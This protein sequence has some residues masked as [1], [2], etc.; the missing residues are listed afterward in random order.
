MNLLLVY[1]HQAEIIIVK[2]I[3]QGRN[4]V[5]RVESGTY[6]YDRIKNDSILLS[7]TL[8]TNHL[9]SDKPP[10]WVGQKFQF[11]HLIV[12][13]FN[14]SNR[15]IKFDLVKLYLPSDFQNSCQTLCSILF[16][17]KR[18]LE[19]QRITFFSYFNPERTVENIWQIKMAKYVSSNIVSNETPR[20]EGDSRA[21]KNFNLPII[22]FQELEIF[23]V[24]HQ[25]FYAG[26][27]QADSNL[28][29]LSHS[30]QHSQTKSAKS[31]LLFYTFFKRCC[32]GGESSAGKPL[33][34][35]TGNVSLD[36][37]EK[38]LTLFFIGAKYSIYLLWWLAWQKNLQREPKK[39]WYALV[40][41]E[42][43]MLCA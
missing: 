13:K 35:Q 14:A 26:L 11:F 16:K 19:H 22:F 27:L 21:R 25:Y 42:K 7:V 17:G 4:N 29:L 32:L 38:Q 15:R 9:S 24:F 12:L 41:V 40:Y 43:H 37:W 6:D 23:L 34:S 36:P 28:H 10:F 5:T 8:Q 20:R 30:N 39:E 1:S 33:N 3:I 31:I 2:C 18:A